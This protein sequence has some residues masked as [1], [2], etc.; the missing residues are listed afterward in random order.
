MT[1]I[2]VVR[3]VCNYSI[4]MA[5]ERYEYFKNE[6]PARHVF[7]YYDRIKEDLAAGDCHIALELLILN[8][9]NSSEAMLANW[10]EFNEF[11]ENIRIVE[12]SG[13]NESERIV[14]EYYTLAPLWLLWPHIRDTKTIKE[15]KTWLTQALRAVA[16]VGEAHESE[17]CTPGGFHKESLCLCVMSP[18]CPLQTAANIIAEPAWR[19]KTGSIDENSGVHREHFVTHLKVAENQ[20]LITPNQTQAILLQYDT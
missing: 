4:D 18:S 9:L 8:E 10:P 13:L 11:T 7:F 19:E 6:W 12:S 17:G 16:A 1:L 14:K 2:L 15:S 20:G 3:L 5:N